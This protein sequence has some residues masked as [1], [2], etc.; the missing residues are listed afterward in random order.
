MGREMEEC[1]KES[2]KK[3]EKRK[4]IHMIIFVKQKSKR[5]LK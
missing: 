4:G 2:V 3:T 5:N 1:V